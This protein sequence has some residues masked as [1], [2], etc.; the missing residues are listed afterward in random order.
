MEKRI[1]LLRIRRVDNK[2]VNRDLQWIG[3]S[4]GLFGQRDKDSSCFRVFI[5]LVK[6]A[7]ET[8]PISSDEI[9]GKL[10]LT[11]GTVVHHLN[12]LMGSGIVVREKEGYILRESNLRRLIKDLQND[13]KSILS[14][15]EDVAK[16]VDER[17]E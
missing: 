6:R 8:S 12:K 3:N 13:V 2:N 10:D 5:T 17:L 11:R 16:A 9:A 15:L 7:K 4:L 14:D 1:T